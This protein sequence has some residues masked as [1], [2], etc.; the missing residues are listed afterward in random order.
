MREIK[1]LIIVD[2]NDDVRIVVRQDEQRQFVNCIKP[3]GTDKNRPSRTHL[4]D[5]TDGC[6][7]DWVHYLRRRFVA[8]LVQQLER[9][10]V[11]LEAIVLRKLL[12]NGDEPIFVWTRIGRKLIE[13][14][15]V[16]QHV[17]PEA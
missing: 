8:R 16:H 6:R 3:A 17:E 15:Y 12:P 7:V 1:R 10:A 5:F 13:V 4:S 2:G 9:E 14:M 11:G